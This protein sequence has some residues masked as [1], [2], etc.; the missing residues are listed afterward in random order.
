MVTDSFR[1]KRRA[2]LKG[3]PVRS[4]TKTTFS[5]SCDVDVRRQIDARARSLG[6]DR[7]TYMIALA[8]QDFSNPREFT[9][10]PREKLLVS[11][12]G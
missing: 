5:L 3:Q 4:P 10:V 7:S 11:A 9:I 8:R 6:L 1:H 2:K 12:G